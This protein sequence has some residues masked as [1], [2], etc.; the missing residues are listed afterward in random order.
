MVIAIGISDDNLV[1]KEKVSEDDD[2][3]EDIPNDVSSE[4]NVS[5]VD[6]YKDDISVDDDSTGDVTGHDLLKKSYVV[7]LSIVIVDVSDFSN[8]VVDVV[9]NDVVSEGNV[10]IV[11]VSKDDIS[12]DNDSTG[13]VTGDDILKESSVVELSIDIVD[14]VTDFS[15]NV[16]DGVSI[17]DVSID[18]ISVDVPVVD[19]LETFPT[20]ELL[21]DVLGDDVVEVKTISVVVRTFVVLGWFSMV[22]LS[23]TGNDIKVS[24]APVKTFK[25]EVWRV[26]EELVTD[27]ETV[28][29]LCFKLLPILTLDIDNVPMFTESVPKYNLPFWNLHDLPIASFKDSAL[30]L[31][32]PRSRNNTKSTLILP[33][34]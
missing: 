29:N 20:V 32:P 25:F 11:D 13:D 16:V 10:F 14:D 7:E 17:V 23:C 5:I 15:N 19:V 28:D 2:S 18:I 26:V 30:I 34:L 24:M 31:F 6:V 33:F 21:I 22:E 12:V 1:S 9:S 8:N 3:E 27:G 4:G